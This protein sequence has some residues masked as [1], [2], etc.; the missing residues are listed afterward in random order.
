MTE[1]Y[2]ISDAL[3]ELENLE[4][5]DHFDYNNVLRTLE[6]SDLMFEARNIYHDSVGFLERWFVADSNGDLRELAVIDGMTSGVMVRT[7]SNV[8]DGLIEAMR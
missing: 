6:E 5:G 2:S 7:T 8:K 4:A 1:D 3:D